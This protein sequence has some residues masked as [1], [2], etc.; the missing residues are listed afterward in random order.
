VLPTSV[1]LKIPLA[2]FLHSQAASQSGVRY[3]VGFEIEFTLLK[4]TDDGSIQPVNHHPWSATRGLLDGAPE[5]ACLEA[6][7]EIL[8][9]CDIQVEMYH[10]EGAPGQVLLPPRHALPQLI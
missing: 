10:V 5:T 2:N 1:T 9:E 3:L 6:I 8:L 4:K 7:V